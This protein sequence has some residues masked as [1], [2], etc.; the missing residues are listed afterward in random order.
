M[1]EKEVKV[2]EVPVQSYEVRIYCP[3]CG[4]RME[5]TGEKLLSYPLYYAHMCFECG[6]KIRTKEKDSDIVYKKVNKSLESE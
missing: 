3:E 5:F 1:K 2:E 6:K 4:N